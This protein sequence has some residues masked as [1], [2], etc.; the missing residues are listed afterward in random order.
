MWSALGASLVLMA[1]L[2]AT[3][4][5]ATAQGE[6]EVRRVDGGPA[7]PDDV[8]AIAISACQELIGQ[9]ALAG[10]VLLARDDAFADALAA[11]P[12]AGDTGC[13]LY[14]GPGEQ[15]LDPVVRAEI[16]RV[17][18][19][20][21]EV[22]LVGG[23]AA[24]GTAAAEEL[25][26]AGYSPRRIAGATR[27]ET[28]AALAAA[29]REGQDEQAFREV[30][31]AYGGDYPDAV[32]AGAYAAAQG[33][34]V[35]LTD[36]P[37]LHPAAEAFLAAAPVDRTTVVGG[38][39]VISDAAAS[40]APTAVRIAGDTRM[41]TAAA[42]ARQLWPTADIAPAR[43][44]LVDLEG[45]RAWA[46]ALSAAPLAALRGTPQLGTA[47]DR[48][49]EETRELLAETGTEGLAQPPGI[50]VVGG[51]GFVADA[52]A[53]AAAAALGGGGL[54]GPGDGSLACAPG[55]QDPAIPGD[56]TRVQEAV[57]DL[58]G[59]DVADVLTTYAVDDGAGGEAFSLHVRLGTGRTAL[60]ALQA[61]SIADVR[62]LGAADIGAGRQV[63]FVVEQVGA[64]TVGVALF[65][66]HDF[67]TEPCE[68]ARVTIADP[69]VPP[70][71]PVYG[72]SGLQCRDVD[73]DGADELVAR[74]VRQVDA[75]T[76][77]WAEQAY[78]WPG[79]GALRT[80]LIDDGTYTSPED[81]AAIAAVSALECPGVAE[82]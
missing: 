69:T 37:S 3:S 52:V 49:P 66:L 76:W 56:A 17:L 72:G 24:V 77:E 33:V 54:G 45:P 65:G 48:L 38:T 55:P 6:V 42:V 2:L 35:I 21:G 16:D 81:D 23:T 75:D 32:T 53:E 57:G 7:A 74:Q 10:R 36:T 30:V 8:R 19:P 20:G 11:A 73:D 60:H 43:F 71:L 18:P 62:P 67:D 26:A 22:V 64:S 1:A 39:A 80:A 9:G 41:G 25:A 50:L 61:D 15:P 5:T 27:Y 40:A 79:V 58:D 78:T 44:M 28:A 14:T 4:P 29:V 13:I 70:Q 46:P 68:L 31:L 51:Q 12:L 63:A 47:T 82:P 59:D 34:P